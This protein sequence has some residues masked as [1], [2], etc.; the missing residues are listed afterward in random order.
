[1]SLSRKKVKTKQR[2]WKRL[3]F[4]LLSVNLVIIGSVCLFFLW[5]T[6]PLN[7]PKSEINSNDR[8]SEFTI[9]T[10]KEN[11][12]ELVNAYLD[13]LLRKTEHHYQI[14]LGEDVRLLGELPVFSTKVPLSV[15]LEPEVQPNGD[16]VLKQKSISLGLL[17]LPNKQIM[18]YMKTFLS[19]SVTAT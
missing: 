14:S 5:P 15:R 4:I 17:E 9:R 10:S 3:F 16:I 6:K 2:N 19:I 8:Y 1:M 12:N 11:V 7:L 13:H 18:K